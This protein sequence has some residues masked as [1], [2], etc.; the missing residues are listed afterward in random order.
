MTTKIGRHRV[1]H[2]ALHRP[3]I[4]PPRELQADTASDTKG[5]RGDLTADVPRGGHYP[6]SLAHIS[7]DAQPSEVI[8]V[9]TPN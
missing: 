4:N 5:L 8:N 2:T 9:A 3:A 6:H 7:G 1:M